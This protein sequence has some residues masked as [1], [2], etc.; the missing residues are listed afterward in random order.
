LGL[1]RQQTGS[2]HGETELIGDRLQIGQYAGEVL[3]DDNTIICCGQ[4][5]EAGIQKWVEL[6][7]DHLLAQ[8]D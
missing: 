7:L 5:A 8:S 4:R 2:R 6:P 3:W 1:Q